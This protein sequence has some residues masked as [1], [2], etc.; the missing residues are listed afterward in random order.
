MADLTSSQGSNKPVKPA[1]PNADFP[2]FP[3]ANGSWAKKIKGKLV[4]FGKWADPQGALERYQQQVSGVATPQADAGK[5]AK[6]Y[7]TFPLSA[8]GNGQWVKRIR[9][10]L[11][12]FGKWSDW[13]AAL[14]L[15]EKQKSD[16]HAGR[17]PRVKRG[18]MTLRDL[19]NTFMKSKQRLREAG[20]LSTRMFAD[21]YQT[22]ADLVEH[23]N[24]DRLAF[25]FDPEDWATFRAKRAKKPGAIVAKG[26][27]KYGPVALGNWVQRIRTIFKFGLDTGLLDAPM[28]FGTEFVKPKKKSVRKAKREAG[29]RMFQ[30][31]EVRDLLGAASVQMRPMIYLAINAGLGNTDCAMLKT[32]HIDFENGWLNFPRPKT[33]VDRR[34]RLWV[35]TLEAIRQALTK[36]PLPKDPQH[37]GHVFI[38]KYGQTWTREPK[39]FKGEDG[40]DAVTFG[41]NA[42]AKE[43]GKLCK[44]LGF[45]HSRG[46][47]CLRH[48]FATVAGDSKDQIAVDRVMG[49]VDETMSGN[50]R[51]SIDDS[52]LEAV[53]DHVH[54]WLSPKLALVSEAEAERAG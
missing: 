16:L 7:P 30:A 31:G 20:E 29:P 19:C 35:E 38:T 34:C 52:R 44:K 33:E 22:C 51:E 46:F 10:K 40:K 50:Y 53:A 18:S 12:Y 8:H 13:Q 23:F 5:P 32:S 28:R 49:H 25:D 41:D 6:P 43:F 47:Y 3:H 27:K 48:S 21:Y 2:L 42:L 45:N 39:V 11:H 54:N 4:Y 14:D 1:K 17:V 36:R 24:R 15:Y 26:S 37:E 9:G